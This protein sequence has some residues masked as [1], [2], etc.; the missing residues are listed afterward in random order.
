M[1]YERKNSHQKRVVGIHFDILFYAV[2]AT[3]PF[4]VSNITQSVADISS[5]CAKNYLKAL[6]GLGYIEKVTCY[7]YQATDFAKELCGVVV[8]SRD[9]EG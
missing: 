3:A 6:V 7:K 5:E 9:G 1:K 8:T 4:Q 2:R